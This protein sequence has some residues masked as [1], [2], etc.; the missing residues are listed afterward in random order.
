MSIRVSEAVLAVAATVAA[1]PLAGLDTVD[2]EYG[3]MD[4]YI[5]NGL[6]LSDSTIQALRAE[7]L[8]GA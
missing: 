7:F 2:K 6:G 4:L 5:R 3:S 1:G 8:I